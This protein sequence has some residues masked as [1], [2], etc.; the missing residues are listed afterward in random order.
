M[1][2][3]ECKKWTI[4][5]K[6]IGEGK[7]WTQFSNVP[8][9]SD[10][11]QFFLDEVYSISIWSLFWSSF[12]YL[13]ST[14]TSSSSSSSSS[15]FSISSFLP[16]F[17]F[18]HLNPFKK[19]SFLFSPSLLTPTPT[20]IKFFVLLNSMK[21]DFHNLFLLLLSPQNMKLHNMYIS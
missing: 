4:I 21:K 7:M 15:F 14:T 19:S 2:K 18:C 9:T 11:R 20:A 8:K 17:L 12:S 3:L 16:H 1:S 6:E 13:F 10:Y 5:V